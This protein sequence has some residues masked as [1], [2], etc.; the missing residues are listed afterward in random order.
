GLAPGRGL[1]LVGRAP[2]A[3][4]RIDDLAAPPEVAEPALKC[5]GVGLQR[6]GA[7]HCGADRLRH[8]QQLERR[9]HV[10][11]ARSAR[12]YAGRLR[13]A[14]RRRG[15]FFFVFLV[16]PL[17][18]RRERGAPGLVEAWLAAALRRPVAADPPAPPPPP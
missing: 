7:Q 13:L 18:L 14:R 15:V 1:A 2:G 3:R 12:C 6:A 16:V 8:R 10:A 9:Q 17:E 5:G 4:P 11:A